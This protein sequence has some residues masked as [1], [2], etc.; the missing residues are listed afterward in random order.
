MKTQARFVQM[1]LHLHR[2]LHLQGVLEEAAAQRGLI[3]GLARRVLNG[4]LNW[5]PALRLCHAVLNVDLHVLMHF[6]YFFRQ[7]QAGENS[8]QSDA[9]GVIDS[10]HGAERSIS[11]TRRKLARRRLT[12]SSLQQAGKSDSGI[13]KCVVGIDLDRSQ[14]SM[15]KL[16][17]GLSLTLLIDKQNDPHDDFH[18]DEH[19]AKCGCYRLRMV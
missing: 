6:Y 8:A 18:P 14:G 16:A 3:V 13:S 19:Q 17:E 9:H 4:R 15:T 7:G 11:V 5:H 12:L 1:P 2:C 10:T